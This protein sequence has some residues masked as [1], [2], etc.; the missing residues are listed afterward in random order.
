[1]H[2]PDLAPD[3]QGNLSIV[4]V[5]HMTKIYHQRRRLLKEIRQ[6]YDLDVVYS[7]KS[8]PTEQHGGQGETLWAPLDPKSSVLTEGSTNFMWMW[9]NHYGS[10]LLNKHF[11][12][13]L[14]HLL[15]EV[16]STHARMPFTFPHT[17][18]T[19]APHWKLR[20]CGHGG[21]YLQGWRLELA[22]SRLCSFHY[23]LRA[24]ENRHGRKFTALWP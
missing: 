24:M 8:L 9:V 11:G 18:A 1:M 19:H 15:L 6:G 20:G 7:A 10:G 5:L 22:P 13:L 16:S 4:W 2:I 14:L 21:L 17:W 23:Y 3:S 12:F